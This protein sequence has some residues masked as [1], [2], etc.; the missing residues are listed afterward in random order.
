MGGAE[1]FDAPAAQAPWSRVAELAEA[2]AAREGE[3][4]VDP[5]VR[6]GAARGLDL[7]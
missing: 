2:R 7:I 3:G 6:S 1:R 5:Q 4:A